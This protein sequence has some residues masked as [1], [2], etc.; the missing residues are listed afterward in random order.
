[1]LSTVSEVSR[2]KC[3]IYDGHPSEQ[4]PV[5]VPLLEDGLRA[6]ERCLYLGDP[7]MVEMVQG[8]LSGRGVDVPAE[9]QRGSLV[10]SSDRP[11]EDAFD[12]EAMVAMLVDMIDGAVQDGFAG[13]C[14]TGDMR[15]EL[16]RD[17]NFDRV[18]EYEALLERVFR[19]KPLRGICQY[20]R[21]TVP[22]KGLE[23]AVRAHRSLFVGNW[24]NRDNLFYVP[25]ELLLEE[26]ENGERL[27][28][29]MCQQLVRIMQAER[30]RDQAL[31][32]LRASESQQR[33][34]AEEL[35]DS[36]RNLEKR[37][38]ER[39]RELHEANKE[40]EAFAYSVSHDL[41]QPVSHI[42][43][44][45]NILAGDFGEALGAKGLTYVTKVRES[46]Q[47]MNALIEGMLAVGRVGRREL[48]MQPVD[49]T[50]LASYLAADL[51]Q[52]EPSRK[53]EIRIDPDMQVLGDEVLLQAALENLL[54]NA[55]KF[56]GKRDVARI[57]VRAG[58]VSNGFQSFRVSDNGA[59][60]DSATSATKLFGLF[61]RLHSQDDL[62]GTGV[63]LATVDRIV[64]RHGGRI[65]AESARDRGAT[66][67]F[68]LPIVPHAGAPLA[69]ANEPRSATIVAN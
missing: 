38:L 55:W 66:F 1:M 2:H 26:H 28:G 49:L 33:R 10:F 37:V 15:W 35:A 65:W 53:V 34:L 54:G 51:R 57:E 11:A 62:K 21:D 30:L 40:L 69:H 46:S 23:A 50:L 42:D 32:A 9:I 59:G 61:Q 5:I 3:L 8:A 25:P 22:A 67:H 44:F 7:S 29:W 4:L 24:L 41:R 6:N 64:R 20:H 39:T 14:A 27:G 60:F 36:N 17:E 31:D 48:V 12:P 45:T 18:L 68:T 43:G 58:D 13:L 16:G 52:R 63:G 19:S 47:R 56:T